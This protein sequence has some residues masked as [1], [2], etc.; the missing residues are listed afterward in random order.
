MA[1][2]VC[3]YGRVC[4]FV[5]VCV[6]VC[7]HL[8]VY[9]CATVCVYACVHVNVYVLVCVLVCVLC[10]LHMCMYVIM[11]M[12][13]LQWSIYYMLAFIN[14]QIFALVTMVT[15]ELVNTLGCSILGIILHWT[16]VTPF[17]AM[18]VVVSTYYPLSS[19][20]IVM[21]VCGNV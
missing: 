7:V 19:M 4:V 15:S 3:V 17:S 6:C 21:Y 2:T 8:H 18:A 10:T 1:G 20:Y 16:I 14:L 9:M 13:D 5:C 12:W 11:S